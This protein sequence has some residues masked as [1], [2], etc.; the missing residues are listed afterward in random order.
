[1]EEMPLH[2]TPRFAACHAEESARHIPSREW[3]ERVAERYIV[4][5][6]QERQRG[7][8]RQPCASTSAGGEAGVESV[9]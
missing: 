4:E 3:R 8:N 1:M 6:R 7:G 2:V 9:E 5:D